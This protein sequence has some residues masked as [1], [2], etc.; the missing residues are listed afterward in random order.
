MSLEKKKVH[1]YSWAAERLLEL[2]EEVIE[3]VD[4]E[5]VELTE[6]KL[7]NPSEKV[8]KM[9]QDVLDLDILEI[10]QLM[11]LIQVKSS[12]SFV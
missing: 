6:E 5:L 2:G 4:Q 7:A 3:P 9:A 11:T 8:K 10:N 12:I 1:R